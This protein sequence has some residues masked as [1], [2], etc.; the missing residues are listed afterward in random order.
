MHNGKQVFH[1]FLPRRERFLVDDDL[2]SLLT[3]KLAQQVE[4][5]RTW[6]L[7]VSKQ[8]ALDLAALDAFDQLTG[9]VCV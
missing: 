7:L 3:R 8:N 2:A 9:G 6:P 1:H 5:K 4:P